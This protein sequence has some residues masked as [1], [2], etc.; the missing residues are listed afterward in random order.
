MFQEGVKNVWNW[1]KKKYSFWRNSKHYKF[2]ITTMKRQ[3]ILGQLWDRKE[4]K[5]LLL[6]DKN[7]TAR[8]KYK[9]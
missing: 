4:I 1:I 9:F 5:S 2:G 7:T 6:R 3:D 8:N